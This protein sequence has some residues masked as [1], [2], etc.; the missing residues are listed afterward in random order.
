MESNEQNKLMNKL[1]P[2]IW[3]HGTDWKWPDRKGEGD[4]GRKKEGIDKEHVWM[5][6][7]HEQ[8]CGNGL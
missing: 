4:N 6:Q 3:K 1:E 2:Q 5:T 8:Q 7:E